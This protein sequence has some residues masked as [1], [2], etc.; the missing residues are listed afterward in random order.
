[1]FRHSFTVKFFWLTKLKMA[2]LLTRWIAIFGKKQFAL[3]F[4]AWEIFQIIIKN[5]L[6]SSLFSLHQMLC[7]HGY[8][9]GR[10]VFPYC[11]AEVCAFE[12]FHLKNSDLHTA[13]ANSLKHNLIKRYNLLKSLFLYYKL[14]NLHL[15]IF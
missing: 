6:T 14:L 2:K 9:F 8:Y 1:M 4:K 3:Y 15:F 12:S 11:L 10:E 13:T 5:I 7:E